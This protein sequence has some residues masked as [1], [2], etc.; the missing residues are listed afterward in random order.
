MPSKRSDCAVRFDLYSNKNSFLYLLKSLSVSSIL[1]AYLINFDEP[2]EIYV[3]ISDADT[4]FFLYLVSTV[5]R[6]LRKSGAVSIRVPSK[7]NNTSLVLR[8]SG[9]HQIINT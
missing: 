6:E 3:L 5:L 4:F 8:F 1:K 2:S 9:I 7:S